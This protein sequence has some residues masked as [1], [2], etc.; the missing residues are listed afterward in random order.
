MCGGRRRSTNSPKPRSRKECRLTT[1]R[2]GGPCALQIEMRSAEST[3]DGPMKWRVCQ[4]ARNPFP[5]YRMVADRSSPSRVR[6]AASRPG[7]LRADPK[8]WLFTRGKGGLV[9]RFYPFKGWFDFG[10]LIRLIYPQSSSL[11]LLVLL[12]FVLLLVRVCGNLEESRGKVCGNLENR[13]LGVCGNLVENP[14]DSH[15]PV[16]IGDLRFL[17]IQERGGVPESNPT[18]KG[19]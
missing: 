6:F 16:E 12:L 15:K 1:I 19:R 18:R 2:H 4:W 13:G 3:E 17:T 8:R 9:F 11:L 10:F 7:L 14:L 5:S